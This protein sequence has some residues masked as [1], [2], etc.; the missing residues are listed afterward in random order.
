MDGS[1]DG[2]SVPFPETGSEIVPLSDVGVVVLVYDGAVCRFLSQPASPC[3]LALLHT[4]SGAARAAVAEARKM[5]AVSVE[6]IVAAVG[7]DY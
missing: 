3:G 5:M 2:H 7:G 6:R 1:S 4:G